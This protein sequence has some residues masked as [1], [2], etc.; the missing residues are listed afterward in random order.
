MKTFNE[1]QEQ[2]I[3]ESFDNNAVNDLVNQLNHTW[4]YNKWGIDKGSRYIKVWTTIGEDDTSKSV[5]FF[6]D[7]STGAILK[8]AGWK[9]PSKTVFGHITDVDSFMKK[10]PRLIHVAK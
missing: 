2:L 9:K 10:L 5:A 3:E 8:A 4:T 7:K 6:V 1:L